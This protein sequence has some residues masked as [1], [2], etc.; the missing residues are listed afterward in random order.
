MADTGSADDPPSTETLASFHVSTDGLPE[1]H[2]AGIFREVFGRQMFRVDFEG[3]SMQPFRAEISGRSLPGLDL[4]W[5]EM[6]PARVGR[7]AEFVRDGNDSIVIQ[8]VEKPVHGRQLGR[9][10]ALAPGDAVALSN[11]DPNSIALPLGASWTALNMP[12]E[13]LTQLLRDGEDCVA[14]PI[15]RHSEAL[16]LLIH[17]VKALRGEMKLSEPVLRSAVVRH[18]YDVVAIALGATRDAAE[19]AKGRGVRAARLRAIKDSIRDNLANGDLSVSTL[20]AMHRVTPRYVQ[21]LFDD[22]GTT[23]TGYIRDQRLA[24]ACRMLENPHLGQQ[25]IADIAFEC[26]F[27]DISYFNRSFRARY[28]AT[29]SDVRNRDRRD[30]V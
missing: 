29:P 20:A 12:R 21:M 23:F 30:G 15:L 25:K 13:A 7:T 26:G 28:R 8:W 19:V 24:R 4:A 27:G 9:E 10:F 11:A 18:L 17:Y 5:A 16:Q 3:L 1:A 14:R 2:R 6:S 22:E